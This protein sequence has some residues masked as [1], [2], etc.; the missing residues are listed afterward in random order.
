MGAVERNQ[1]K[2]KIAVSDTERTMIVAALVAYG[3][4]PLAIRIN[5]IVELT[6]DP[7]DD[8]PEVEILRQ[9]RSVHA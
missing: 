3:A 2:M 7:A 1:M 9:P 5:S 6:R 8:G 4:D